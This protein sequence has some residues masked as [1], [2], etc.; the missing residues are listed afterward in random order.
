MLPWYSN[1]CRG[2]VC[3][4]Q[5]EAGQGVP[6]DLDFSWLGRQAVPG[7]SP[8]H[9][10][11]PALFLQHNLISYIQQEFLQ[12]I[13]SFSTHCRSRT[14]IGPI[15]A[16]PRFI[17]LHC[18]DAGHRSTWLN[19]NRSWA[20]Y[21]T[22][23]HIRHISADLSSPYSSHIRLSL[24]HL[25]DPI[26]PNNLFGPS[27]VAQIT[28]I[29]LPWKH[30]TYLPTACSQCTILYVLRSDFNAVFRSWWSH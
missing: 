19:I 20:F 2:E 14:E 3:V 29:T 9:H 12:N 15:P 24:I 30:W 1:V 5:G 17:R 27:S 22:L 21:V 7:V 25:T 18:G 26:W 10:T 16:H 4:V 11:P 8:G 6:A 28:L 23:M 13:F